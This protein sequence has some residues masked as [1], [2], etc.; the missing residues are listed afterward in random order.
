MRPDVPGVG[1][2]WS[3]IWS[4]IALGL[5]VT[6]VTAWLI[7]D[8]R[9]RTIADRQKELIRFGILVTEV[10][11]RALQ[12][13]D[14]AERD[15]LEDMRQKGVETA[16]DLAAYAQPEAM[17]SQLA[18]R[19]AG[20]PQS[21]AL[22]IIDANGAVLSFSALWPTPATNVAY[23][24]YFERAKSDGAPNML[25]SLTVPNY[26]DGRPALFMIRRVTATNGSFLGIIIGR[27]R[28]RYFEDLY[29]TYYRRVPAQ[30]PFP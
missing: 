3:V 5:L 16:A 23:R 6:G 19:I 7:V 24:P 28:S 26:S 25:L 21:E 29:R 10:A 11:E 15:V 2:K 8:L 1:S 9:A 12:A 20:L 30:S 18:K 17:H 22:S 13:I 27:V 14:L 4:G